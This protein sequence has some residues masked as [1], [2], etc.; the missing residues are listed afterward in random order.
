TIYTETY[1]RE[2]V[3][4][5]GSIYYGYRPGSWAGAFVGLAWGVGDGF[6]GTL[7]IVSLY[8]LLAGCCRRRGCRP[9]A[10]QE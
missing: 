4:V 8:N 6:I 7:I 1:A 10:Q 5:L 2:M 9:A 3:E